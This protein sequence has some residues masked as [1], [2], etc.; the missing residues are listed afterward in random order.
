MGDNIERVATVK[1]GPAIQVDIESE[2]GSRLAGLGLTPSQ[3]RA[4][5]VLLIDGDATATEVAL[6]AGVA[7]QKIYD[8]LHTLERHGFCAP[9]GNRVA[10]WEAL[11]PETALPEWVAYRERERRSEAARERELCAALLPLL[12]QRREA[13]HTSSPLL[14]ALIGRT[15]IAN[16]FESLV[17]RAERQ[18]DVVQAVPMVQDPGRWNV[19]E[20]E[21]ITRGVDV[22]VLCTPD[23][24][25]NPARYADILRG[26]GQARITNK[27]S[28]K[29]AIRD[30]DEALV[31]LRDP[32]A[33]IGEEDLTAMHILQPDLVAP[34]VTL[35]RRG[36]RQGTPLPD[37]N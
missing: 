13:M 16:A 12:P 29:L 19:L 35:F 10:R 7:R 30:G 26:G 21:A 36:W 23:A 33:T 32:N 22:R 20:L 37:G 18:L 5:L 9:T 1:P 14:E 25:D 8:V 28:L 3:S 2:L 4:Y 11:A 6:R 17:A 27:L 24:T 34:L 31:A 15:R